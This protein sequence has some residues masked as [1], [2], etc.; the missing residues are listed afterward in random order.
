MLVCIGLLGWGA[1]RVN[2]LDYAF[3]RGASRTDASGQPLVASPAAFILSFV[4]GQVGGWVAWFFM[5]GLWFKMKYES[6][7]IAILLF[8]SLRIYFKWLIIVAQI[9]QSSR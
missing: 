6:C 4:V 1:S 8:H 9:L 3:K 7:Y 5:K 2:N